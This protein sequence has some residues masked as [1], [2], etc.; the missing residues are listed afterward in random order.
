[1]DSLREKV[2]RSVRD[3]RALPGTNPVARLSDVDRRAADAAIRAV[4]DHLMEPS[5]GMV[6]AGCAVDGTITAGEVWQAML[7]KAREEAGL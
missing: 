3:A 7:T 6:E 2:A 4:F 1:M 5:V